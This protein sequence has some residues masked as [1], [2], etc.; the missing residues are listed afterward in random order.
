MREVIK[1]AK[2]KTKAITVVDFIKKLIKCKIGTNEVENMTN[3]LADR[4]DRRT[5]DR[6]VK[7]IIV[8]M[9]QKLLDAINVRKM[10]YTSHC[11]A[12]R[13]LWRLISPRSPPACRFLQAMRQEMTSLWQQTKTKM[14][15]KIRH[16]QAKY[17]PQPINN[18]RGI[19]ISDSE[20]GEA[21]NPKKPLVWGNNKDLVISKLSDGGKAILS[22]P[23]KT[24]TY[25][26]ITTMDME[27]QVEKMTCKWRWGVQ[28]DKRDKEDQM[29]GDSRTKEEKD[30]DEAVYHPTKGTLRM[31]KLRASHLTTVRE[32]TIPPMGNQEEEQK[33]SD[34]KGEIVAILQ[35]SQ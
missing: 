1:T 35:A 18:I 8:I 19:K 34:L 14:S 10:M 28:R 23:P 6:D 3:R 24:T 11:K 31:D 21:E 15:A 5:R 4:G 26:N 12:K 7:M 32:T 2:S 9:K 17:V 13:D 22:M 29:A 27:I 20:L 33:L 16:L 25:K 30:L